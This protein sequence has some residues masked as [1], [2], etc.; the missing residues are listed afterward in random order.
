MK[1]II[2]SMALLMLLIG[3]TTRPVPKTYFDDA[4]TYCKTVKNL[5]EV[6]KHVGFPPIV[7]TRVYTYANIAAYE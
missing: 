1:C 3:C 7:A 2:A 4:F 6:V 5:N